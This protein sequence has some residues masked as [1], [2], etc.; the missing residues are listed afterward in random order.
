MSVHYPS[1]RSSFVAPHAIAVLV[2]PSVAIVSS[3]IAGAT[4]LETLTPHGFV[5]GDRVAVL[6]HL[7]ST[8]A[9][10]GSYIVT[11]I[12]TLHVSIPL[13]VTVAGTG[14]TVTRTLAAEP[15]TLAQGKSL[16]GLQWA[17]GDARDV[18]MQ[19]FI[20]AAR[21]KVEQD[22]GIALLLKTYDVFFDAL[23]DRAPMAMPWRPVA[24]VTSIN[25]IDSAGVVQTLDVANYH[26]DPGSEAP[27]LA[28]VA[29][30]DI[31]AWP[32]DL[33]SFQPFVLRIV[34]GWPS[35]AL[36]PPLLMHALGLLT[37]HYATVGRD[38]TTVG[39]IIATTPYGYEDAISSYVPVVVP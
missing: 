39:T 31:G 15:L 20:A 2:T 16:A 14:G 10:D 25:S 5:S 27:V 37:S 12:D 7:G 23:S 17:D 38:L 11:V 22:T 18:L 34:A 4:V 35:A 36:I 32:T 29:L 24:S 9:V 21:A 28:R 13:A 1:Q 33:R 19:G 8:P 3:S 30:S 26:L 6:G